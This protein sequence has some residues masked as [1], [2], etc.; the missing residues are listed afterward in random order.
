MVFV[1][2]LA[3]TPL[4]AKKVMAENGEV[5]FI[6]VVISDEVWEPLVCYGAYWSFVVVQEI[7]SDP[8]GLLTSSSLVP[9]CYG[10]QHG[11]TVGELVECF[12]FYWLGVCPF[13][14]CGYCDC[15]TGLGNG[16]DYYVIRADLVKNLGTNIYYGMIQ[17]A[18]NANETLDGHTIFVR[19]GTYYENVVINKSVLLMG[20]NREGTIVDG[21]GST[22]FRLQT[23]NVTVTHFTIQNGYRGISSNDDRWNNTICRNNIVNNSYGILAD[24][25]Y[26]CI[27]ENYIGAN[28]LS[29]VSI[30]GYHTRIF[31]N[32]IIGNGYSGIGLYITDWNVIFGNTI[33]DNNCGV[34]FSS[35]ISFTCHNNTFYHNN[36]VNNTDQ[37][38]LG[39]SANTTFDSGCEG[40][41]W[42]DY[43]ERYPN[44]SYN[45]FGIWNTSY[46]ID[47]YP[48][49]DNYPLRNLFWNPADTNH[50][51]IVDIFDIVQVVSFYNTYWKPECCHIDIA[52]PYGIIN[53]FDIVMI[54]SSYGEEYFT[55]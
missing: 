18:I 32:K 9:I 26:S 33:A 13:Q 8:E 53:I 27:Y 10:E 37:V 44:A 35:A 38:N 7:I 45:E 16:S 6:G 20:E 11:L 55:P 39:N 48:N 42:S 24:G 28:D 12:G 31:N 25:W 52:E 1:V 43:E 17:D 40:N 4:Y 30:M 5:K 23:T 15:G 2:L 54:C 34:S 21:N 19:N 36:F 14:C 3:F 49:H 41:Y 47:G 50:D 51:L 46:V 22:V 29:G